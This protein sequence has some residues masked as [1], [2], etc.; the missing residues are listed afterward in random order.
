MTRRIKA[1]PGELGEE[2]LPQYDWI[3]IPILGLSTIVLLALGTRSIA[4]RSFSESKSTT[5]PCLT[6]NDPSTGVRGIPN[7]VCR[8][9]GMESEPVEYRF[10]SCGHRAGMD[11]GPKSPGTYRIVMVGSSF[12]FGMFVTRE[13]SFAALLPEQLSIQTG[14]RVE[15]YNEALEWEFPAS[16]ALRIPRAFAE[17]PDMILWVL[18]PPDIDK[19]NE[20]LPYYLRPPLDAQGDTSQRIWGRI[21]VSFATHSVTDASALVWAR[22]VSVWT[23]M[24]DR[25]RF[26]PSGVLLQHI[27]Y[28]D[29]NLYLRSYLMQADYEGGFLKSN[30]SE[31]WQNNLRYFDQDDTEIQRQARSACVPLVVVLM[32]N[33]AQ[34]AMISMGE[35]PAGYDPYKLNNE[36]RAIVEN[37]GG[38]YIDVFPYFRT[39]PNPERHYFPVDGHPDSVAHAMFAGFLARELTSGVIPDLKA[40][41]AHQIALAKEN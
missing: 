40:G 15:L 37:R 31:K 29:R 32:P 19:S 38:I 26:S 3:V 23:G 33:R 21:R 27:L 11:C 9:K 4:A 17:Q 20:I 5:I 10:N 12:N 7:S 13:K 35:W 1:G 16:A 36:L 41:S 39:V 14:R 25:F 30:Q 24:V 34:A 8:E 18:T 2:Q 22:V 6:L 28:S